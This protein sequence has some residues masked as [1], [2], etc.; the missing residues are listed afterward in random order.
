MHIFLTGAIQAGKSTVISKTLAM[1][2]IIPRGFRTYFG[3]DRESSAR[4]LY[5]NDA[6]NAQ[7]YREEN[8]VVNFTKG[9]PPQVLTE[10]FD[11]LGVELIRSARANANLILM[12]EC[13]HF[14]RDAVLFQREI[15]DALHDS[16][17]VL[18]VIKPFG[19]GWLDQ[20]RNHPKVSI[21]TVLQENRDILPQ[22]LARQL[23]LNG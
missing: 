22:M 15:L 16:I 4:R 23:T 5:L 17:P 13:G 2:E 9:N 3:P 20:I 14:E 7:I 1:L 21:V 19:S 8:V 11:T 18:G 12:D 6:S 10:R